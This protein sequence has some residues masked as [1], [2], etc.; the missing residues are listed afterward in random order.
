MSETTEPQP[1]KLMA[2][3]SDRLVDAAANVVHAFGVGW[4]LDV[5][6]DR[7]VDAINAINC[8]ALRS[9]AAQEKSRV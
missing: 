9:A 3:F 8:E 4:D 7:L 6:I 2:E 5:V 1:D